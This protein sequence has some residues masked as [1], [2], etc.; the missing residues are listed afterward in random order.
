MPN[1]KKVVVS[2]SDAILNS[3]YVTASITGS[4]IK[5]D[6][7]GS[8]SASLAA[9]EAGAI[10]TTLQEVTD[11]GSS[12]TNSI[13]APSFIGTASYA[14]Y[15]ETAS[16]LPSNTNLNITSISASNAVFQSA[17][18]GYLQTITGSATIVGDAYII[19][20]TD[21][22]TQRYAGVVVQDSGST[23][24]TA[25]LEFDG[26]TND[27]FYEYSDDG[28]AT[29]D[30]GVI[31][32]GPEYNTKGSPT[33][34]T[35][36]RIPKSIGSHHLNDSN[37]SDNG[38]IVSISTPLDI[39]GSIT[40]SDVKID[41]WGSVSAS[42]SALS[43]VSNP[44]LQDVTDN[45][46]T[47]TNDIYISSS[48]SLY[49][50]PTSFIRRETNSG[51]YENIQLNGSIFLRPNTAALPGNGVVIGG[52]GY[53]LSANQS[54]N[55]QLNYGSVSGQMGIY[56]LN[57]YGQDAIFQND[58]SVGNTVDPVFSLAGDHGIHIRPSTGQAV[59]RLTIG[60]ATGSAQ[61]AEI[62][63]KSTAGS[64]LSILNRASGSI[65]LST[66]ANTGILNL[67]ESGNFSVNGATSGFGSTSNP[68][69]RLVIYNTNTSPGVIFFNDG[70]TT[71]NG[72]PGFIKYDHINDSFSIGTNTYT[73][74]S[75][76][77]DRKL[78]LN[79]YGSGTVTGT[80]AY[81]LATDSSGNI[82]E[83]TAATSTLEQVTTAGNI[84][85][86]NIIITGS[87]TNS[88]TLKNN[89][90]AI[91]GSVSGPYYGKT[92]E[93]IYDTVNASVSSTTTIAQLTVPYVAGFTFDYVAFVSTSGGGASSP[94][95]QVGRAG[96]IKGIL[97]GTASGLFDKA[98]RITETTTLD[99]EDQNKGTEGLTFTVVQDSTGN[100]NQ[101]VANTNND[102]SYIINYTLTLYNNPV[103]S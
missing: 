18:I 27:W 40:G 16:F 68:A 46:N 11:N 30:H 31:L 81:L 79:A 51:G 2:G 44:T 87:L 29:T 47:T 103:Y 82:I 37:I 45:G 70:G 83:T 62:V 73:G 65:A 10:S 72:S 12:T 93:V 56:K 66:N 14:T 63:Y 92:H 58:I 8:V 100:S 41:D 76:D 4:D 67:D 61:G 35:N 5:I 89:G 23:L 34:L 28:G 84:T 97:R 94:G 1:W 22:P 101:L 26:Q 71:I 75:L 59:L 95:L 39:T 9:I 38:S 86:N 7:W 90:V 74:F 19:L 43:A 55:A 13:T 60:S 6:D 3:L 91:S 54:R 50:G 69:T 80:P 15:A 32:F 57:V 24:T 21:I 20:N 77:T 99:L 52:N 98:F 78:R 48:K 85:G 96:T 64:D 49:L 88:L 42:L 102:W 36:N 33:Y 25:S 17:S 53:L